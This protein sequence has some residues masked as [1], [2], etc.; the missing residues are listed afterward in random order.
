LRQHKL[1]NGI[2]YRYRITIKGFKGKGGASL[3]DELDHSVKG[4]RWEDMET[5]YAQEEADAN[6]TRFAN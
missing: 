4:F 1:K 2:S 3:L 5:S 6:K